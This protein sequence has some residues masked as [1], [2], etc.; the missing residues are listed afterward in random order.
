MFEG[1][2]NV[3]FDETVVDG[4]EKHDFGELSD[5]QRPKLQS[6]IAGKCAYATIVECQCTLSKLIYSLLEGLITRFLPTI[7]A[8]FMVNTSSQQAGNE[9]VPSEDWGD[10]SRV[11]QFA[12]GNKILL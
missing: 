1:V 10:N 5:R 4:D 11:V 8:F 3:G 6:S 2:A 7:E 9:S 12:A